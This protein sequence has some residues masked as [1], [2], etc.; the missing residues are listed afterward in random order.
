ML[1]LRTYYAVQERFDWFLHDLVGFCQRRIF[2]GVPIDPMAY[3]VAW[4]QLN[5][6]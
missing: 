2:F 6:I 4:E 3:L 1:F 5:K